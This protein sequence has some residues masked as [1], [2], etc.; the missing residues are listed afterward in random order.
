[1]DEII[2]NSLEILEVTPEIINDLKQKALMS[3]RKRSRLCM[4]HT[5]NHLTQEMLIV[6]HG[7]SYMPPHRH[8]YGKSESY[9]VVEGTMMVYLFDDAGRMIQ[10]FEMEKAGGRKTF[11][12]RLSDNVWHMPVP[13][14]EWLVY[15]EIYT[16]PFE[17]EL[18]VEF[19]PW[20]PPETDLESAS[21]Y[22]KGLL[23]SEGF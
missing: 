2:I 20:A 3:P 18:D 11:L 10:N 1:M 22:V 6:F 14:S 13:T 17:K 15:H 12:C 5:T 23:T 8:P 19:A 16:G 7:D 9:H 21:R 4:H